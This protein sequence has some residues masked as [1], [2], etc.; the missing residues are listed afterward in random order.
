MAD[1]VLIH[2][3]FRG[4][5]SFARL[6]PLLE[7]AGHRVYAPSLPGAGEHAHVKPKPVTLDTY[8][9]H[10]TRLLELE[11]LTRAIL[12]GHSQGGLVIQAVSQRAHARIAALVFLDAPVPRHG[13][14]AVDLVPPAL[15]GVPMPALDPAAW[16]APRLLAASDELPQADAEWL[17]ARL[18]ET[19]VGPS[20]TPLVLDAPDA[21]RL[22][23]HYLFCRHTP[24]VFPCAH[25]RARFDAEG[26]PYTWIE[27]GHD[28]PFTRP[29]DVA[30]ALLAI[31]A[32]TQ[33]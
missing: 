6:R 14:R 25:A 2:G 33:P 16:L 32:E 21:L 18:C 3:A 13:E 15:A 26:V 19:P 31:E 12:V 7:A 28:A 4:G 30:S 11:D 24:D 20:L 22:P 10:V 29:R 17:N 1:F 9:E 8:T 5:F 23:R 27:A